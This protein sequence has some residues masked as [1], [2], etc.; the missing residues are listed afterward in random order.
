MLLETSDFFFLGILD[1]RSFKGLI[2]NATSRETSKLMHSD[3]KV[4]SSCLIKPCLKKSDVL[5]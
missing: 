3:V 5:I 1:Q 2:L 4:H